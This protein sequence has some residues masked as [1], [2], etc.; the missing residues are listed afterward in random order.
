M[1]TVAGAFKHLGREL[2]V[3][4]FSGVILLFNAALVD[5]YYYDKAAITLINNTLS[6]WILLPVT[7]ILGNIL[8][9]F[10]GVL[11][12]LTPLERLLERSYN[13]DNYRITNKLPLIYIHQKAA[14]MMILDRYSQLS[15][16]RWTYSAGFIL[17]FFILIFFRI[18]NDY[19]FFIRIAI[20]SNALCGILMMILYHLTRIEH[21]MLVKDF[22]ERATNVIKMNKNEDEDG[23][24]LDHML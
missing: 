4:C 16:M 2:T 20:W 1:E 14:Y 12:E 9:A 8:M 19:N 23:F 24:L 18:F 7:Y 17:S 10:Y 3:Y 11:L 22:Y 5:V 6:P 21:I 13:K 15:V